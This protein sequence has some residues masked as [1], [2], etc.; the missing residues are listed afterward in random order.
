[1]LRF[2]LIF[3]SVL[4]SGSGL[5]D[6]DVHSFSSTK[7]Q[8]TY[9]GLTREL[10]CPKCQNQDIA[11]S[12][13]PIAKDMRAQVYRLVEEGKTH[14]EVVDFMIERFGDFVTYKPKVST[15]TLLLW[16]GPW[17]FIGIG[18]LVIVGL[19]RKQKNASKQLGSSSDGV[20]D[21]GQKT[22]Q[23]KAKLDDLLSK[24]DDD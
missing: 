21:E 16:Y 20:A 23:D 12:N 18:F 14:D 6:I 3:L 1:M 4:C 2:I 24:F 11:D 8:E 7:A 22:K 5:A 10:R 15:E 13:A 9:Q 17:V 19:A